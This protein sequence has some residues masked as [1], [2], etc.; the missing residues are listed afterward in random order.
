MD[1]LSSQ[2]LYHLPVRGKTVTSQTKIL[3]SESEVLNLS[4]RIL[5]IICAVKSIYN[6]VREEN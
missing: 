1:S 6:E 2:A 5:I 3:N 4:Q